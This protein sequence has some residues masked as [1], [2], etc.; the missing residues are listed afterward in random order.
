MYLYI[1]D[2]FEEIIGNG[3]NVNN[4]LHLDA[5]GQLIG[6]VECVEKRIFLY[7]LVAKLNKKLISVA[8]MI[9]SCHVVKYIKNFL[10]SVRNF[11]ENINIWPIC[12]RVCID[13][14]PALLIGINQAFINIPNTVSY[15]DRCYD[16][17]TTIGSKPDFVIVC[18]GT[19]LQ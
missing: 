15:L 8:G 14:S 3:L 6:E 7:E 11:C 5:T 10:L 12:K 13:V 1:K 4:T 19:V 18:T 17:L 9:S 16:V 2:V